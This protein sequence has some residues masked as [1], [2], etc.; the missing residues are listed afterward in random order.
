STLLKEPPLGMAKALGESSS[1]K[2]YWEGEAEIRPLPLGP[3]GYLPI[4]PE[5]K[6]FLNEITE[7][8]ELSADK[9]YEAGKQVTLTIPNFDAGEPEIWVLVRGGNQAG[10]VI[11]LLLHTTPKQPVL[12]DSVV[13]YDVSVDRYGIKTDD[14]QKIEANAL[15][16]IKYVVGGIAL[17]NSTKDRQLAGKNSLL[18]GYWLPAPFPVDAKPTSARDLSQWRNVGPWAKLLYKALY[19]YSPERECYAYTVTLKNEYSE[20]ISFSVRADDLFGGTSAPGGWFDRYSQYALEFMKAGRMSERVSMLMPGEERII[21]G[22]CQFKTRALT[23]WVGLVSFE[24][25]TYDTDGPFAA[26]DSPAIKTP[27]TQGTRATKISSKVGQG[28]KH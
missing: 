5:K 13:D 25:D 21:T 8:A 12:F 24:G 23:M 20:P 16:T 17:G 27:G 28:L 6:A 11:G 19:D 2:D 15:R 10:M 7:E 9:F 26:P 14:A 3:T 1:E 22:N 18:K 4:D